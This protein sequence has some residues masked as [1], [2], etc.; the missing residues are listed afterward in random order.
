M[1]VALREDEGGA[2]T[3]ATVEGRL[4]CS[5]P[6]PTFSEIPVQIN[7]CFDL[8]ASRT[9][10]TS[11]DASIGDAKARVEWN[12]LLL[13]HAVASAYVEAL[14]SIPTD[15]AE[16]DSGAFYR[17]WPNATDRDDVPLRQINARCTDAW[18]ISFVPSDERQKP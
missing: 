4:Y 10:L 3:T 7:G 1:A 12:R 16:R 11:D 17:L 8:D 13:K 9:G 18:I 5:L 15:I 14:R 2:S 6:L